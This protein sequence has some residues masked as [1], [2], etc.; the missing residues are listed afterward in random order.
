MEKEYESLV[1]IQQFSSEGKVSRVLG[2]KTGRIHHFLSDLETNVFYILEFDKNVVDIKEHYPLENVRDLIADNDINWEKFNDKKTGEE[3]TITTTFLVT[4]SNNKEVAISC[5]NQSQLY[6]SS[7]QLKLEIERRYWNIKAIDWCIITNKD[8][9][10]T[11]LKNIKW[12][13]LGESL[14]EINPELLK[15]IKDTIGINTGRLKDY[16]EQIGR[17]YNYEDKL[18]LSTMKT[19]IINDYLLINLDEE[20][21]FETN[22]DKFEINEVMLWKY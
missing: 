19:M 14:T 10:N 21:S 13:Q 8:I 2:R 7:T 12:L 18:V 17:T 4:L 20:I 3:Y 9:S 6:K 15:I 5:K 1:K 16:I 11:I 22:I